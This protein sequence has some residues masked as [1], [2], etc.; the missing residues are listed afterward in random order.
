MQNREFGRSH[1]EKS[2]VNTK[3]SLRL[4]RIWNQ[5]LMKSI[6]FNSKEVEKMKIYKT[7]TTFRADD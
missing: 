2:K 3:S 1:N 7:N 5:R 4:F 6:K